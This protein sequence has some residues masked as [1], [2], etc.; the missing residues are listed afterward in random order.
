MSTPGFTFRTPPKEM[1]RLPGEPYKAPPLAVAKVTSVDEDING[2]LLWISED[3]ERENVTIPEYA[4]F[5][6]MPP[7][8]KDAREVIS[9]AGASGAGKSY[10]ARAYAKEYHKMWPDRDIFV[11]SALTSDKTLDVLKYLKRI[12]VSSLVDDPL[13]KG[14][15]LEDFDHSLVIFDDTE[16][17]QGKE[18]D[19]VQH[20]LDSLL[21]LGRHSSTS[22]IVASH[23]PARGKETRLLLSESNRFI[24]MPSAMGYHSLHYLLTTHVGLSPKEVIDLR[25]IKS[26][27]ICL[28]KT[29]PRFLLSSNF[30]RIL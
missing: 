5:T 29:Y 1:K 9:I 8:I 15:D 27:W 4:E 6:L 14:Q 24:V 25:K 16:A 23:L 30:A 20:L 12:D 19:A 2:A 26:R 13:E 11:I 3:G 17:L 28:G 22:V 21:T 18:K 10:L 7:K